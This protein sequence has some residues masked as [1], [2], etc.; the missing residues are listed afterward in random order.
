L[1]SKN[2]RRSPSNLSINLSNIPSNGTIRVVGTTINK[3]DTVFTATAAGNTIDLGYAIRKA[4]GLANTATISSTI[5]ISRVILLNSVTT[6]VSNEIK[7][8]VNEFDLTNYGLNSNSWD[9]Q[10]ALQVSTISKTAFR[11]SPTTDNVSNIITTGTKLQIVFYYSKQNDHEDLFYSRNGTAITNKVF[12]YISSINRL[13]GFQDSGGTISGRLQ[14]NSFN[15]PSSNSSYSV[16]YDYVA[17]KE[18]ERITINFEYNKLIT[19]S[20][21]A[22]EDN[23]PV[24]ADVLVKAATKIELDVSASIVVLPEYTDKKTT[25]QQDVMD[26]ITATLSASAL[27]TTLDSSDIINNIYNVEGVDRVRITKFNKTNVSGTK[28][29][30]TAQENEYLAPGIVIVTVEDR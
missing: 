19:D 28:V 8:V 4:E 9:K 2:M 16:D 11:L 12:G 27:G 1:V 21:E 18:N 26:N 29:S 30:I 5:Q 20:T 13:S 6:T 10:N 24:T 17:P 14:I 22:I 3:V 25:V 23:R 15:Q 7:T